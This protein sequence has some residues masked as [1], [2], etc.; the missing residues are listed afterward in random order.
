MDPDFT[1]HKITKE[2]MIFGQRCTTFLEKMKVWPAT[3]SFFF[4][5]Y[6]EEESSD[7]INNTNNF[8]PPSIMLSYH[9]MHHALSFLRAHKI[10]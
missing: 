8:C 2:K 4:T 10:S 5:F 7:V 9:T 1:I 3:V 6:A